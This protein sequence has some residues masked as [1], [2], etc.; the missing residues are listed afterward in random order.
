M[1]NVCIAI[2]AAILLTSCSEK[3]ESAV[4]AAAPEPKQVASS[5]GRVTLPADSPKL[6]LLKIETISAGEVPENEVVAPGKVEVNP[7]R[8]SH[9]VLPLVG[10]IVSVLVKLGDSVQQGQ[11]LL[12]MESPD[13]DAAVSAYQQAQAQITQAKS[14]LLKAQADLERVRDLR[15]HK[16]IAEKEVINAE[17]VVA[18]T[19]AVIAQNEV[20]QQQAA[21]RLESFGLKPGNYRQ[22]LT[23]SAPISGK[24]LE[25]SIAA[26]EYRNDLATSTMTIADLSS[27]WVAADVQESDI[28][29][30]DPGERVDIELISYPGEV[31]RGKVMRI[32][33]TVDPQTRTV[34]VRAELDNAKG[35][36]RP[37]MFAKM[38]HV[39]GVGRLPLIPAT[40]VF[41]SETSSVAYR[42]VMPGTFEQ[43]SLKLGPHVGDKIAIKS[44][45]SAGDRVVTDGVL[46]LRSN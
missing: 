30:I 38:R 41:Q 32:A 21:V 26:G 11:P 35:R 25:L 29:F 28:R 24:I 27:V 40:A 19:K 33:D 7:N 37:E 46:L 20:A 36:L 12:R 13:T 8:V 6:S 43:V 23:V 45:L 4:Q 16:A 3:K 22:Q 5:D 34:K 42:E 2:V 1:K 10:R 9:V 17:S 14:A 15:D 39:E 44:G 31:Y 18:Q